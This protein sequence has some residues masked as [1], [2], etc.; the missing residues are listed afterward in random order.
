[1]WNAK[2]LKFVKKYENKK[3][4]KIIQNIYKSYIL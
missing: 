4:Y 1:M 2:L 3:N